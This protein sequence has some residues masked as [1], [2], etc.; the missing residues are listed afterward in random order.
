MNA[1]VVT[2]IFDPIRT[3]VVAIDVRRAIRT[4]TNKGPRCG[5]FEF[6]LCLARSAAEPDYQRRQ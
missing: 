3:Y 5:P 2:I 6:M 1:G 4:A